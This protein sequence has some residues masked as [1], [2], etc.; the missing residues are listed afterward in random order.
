VTT[1][2]ESKTVLVGIAADEANSVAAL[3]RAAADAALHGARIT[4]V[5]VIAPGSGPHAADEAAGMLD[6]MLRW[7]VP[8]AL[9]PSARVCIERGEAGP[10][11]AALST[12]AEVLAVGAC[13]NSDRR[14]IYSGSVVRYLLVHAACPL[15]ICADHGRTL[16][17]EPA[18]EGAT[19][20]MAML[21]VQPRQP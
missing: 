6:A 14:G 12:D 10:I 20:V 16:A 3:R 5:H 18:Q 2:V 8:S 15:R 11:L 17:S 21:E 19:N 9:V 7:H 1:S 4:A 13:A